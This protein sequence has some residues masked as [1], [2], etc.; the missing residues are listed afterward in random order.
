MSRKYFW[1]FAAVLMLVA[2]PAF[3]AS[4]NAAL[5]GTVYDASGNPMPGVTITLENP[6][7]AFSRT[8][9]SGSDGTFNFAEVPPA[10]NYRLSASKGGKKLDVR[11]GVTVN[12]GDERVILPPLKA[13]AVAATAQVVEKRSEER[14]VGKECRL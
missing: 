1:A 4:Q 2:A 12:V 11:T 9:T 3:G 13:Q 5:Y 7:L 6:A 8:T 14:R 10:E